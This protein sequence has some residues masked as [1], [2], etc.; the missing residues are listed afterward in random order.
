MFILYWFWALRDGSLRWVVA[1]D[2]P[3]THNGNSA[4][5]FVLFSTLEAQRLNAL[6]LYKCLGLHV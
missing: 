4:R 2:R 5:Y 6:V 1:P 3:T